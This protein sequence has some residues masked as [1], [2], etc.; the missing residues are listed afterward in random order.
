MCWTFLLSVVF[1]LVY[2][3]I[4]PT[5]WVIFSALSHSL[6]ALKLTF[7]MALKIRHHTS[8]S[9]HL[10]LSNSKPVGEPWFLLVVILFL[11][12]EEAIDFHSSRASCW[13]PWLLAIWTQLKGAVQ[14]TVQQ[15]CLHITKPSRTSIAPGQSDRIRCCRINYLN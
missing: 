7:S 2:L 5:I 3:S 10:Y 8:P 11:L 14:Q 4:S 6:Q 1:L 13:N 9:W 15:A 12:P